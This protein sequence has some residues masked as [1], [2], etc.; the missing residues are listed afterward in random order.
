[1]ITI[2]QPI[3]FQRGRQG[4]RQLSDQPAAPAIPREP[5]LPLVAKLMALAIR[6]NQQI[7]QGKITDLSELARLAHVTQPRVTQI[8]NLN[9]LAPDIQEELLFLPRVPAG[10]PPIH[11]KRLRP[12]AAEIDWSKQRAMWR[13]IRAEEETVEAQASDPTPADHRGRTVS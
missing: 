7:Q 8:M 4:R 1:M 9:H 2:T 13:K 11:E 6:F 12:I 10:R 3:T 5:Q